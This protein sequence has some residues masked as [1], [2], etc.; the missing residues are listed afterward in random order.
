MGAQTSGEGGVE[1]PWFRWVYLGCPSYAVDGTGSIAERHA[2]LWFD[3]VAVLDGDDSWLQW[4]QASGPR[5]YCVL[6]PHF[7][8]AAFAAQLAAMT[9]DERRTFEPRNGVTRSS[10]EF[11]VW[12][13]CEADW[14][15][16]PPDLASFV[17]GQVEIVMEHAR[18]AARMPP[19]PKLPWE[20][21][22]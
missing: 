9:P 7:Q 5:R 6:F 12:L 21:E 8:D 11:R 17:Q 3:T 15:D 19:P 10:D 4:W 22:G 16:V 14:T 18:L 13:P 1:G 2:A 20:R